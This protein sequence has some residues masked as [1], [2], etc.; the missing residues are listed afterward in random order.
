LRGKHKPIYTPHVDTGDFV[1]VI[2]AEKVKLTGRK[3]EAKMYHHHTGWVGG[4]VS[5]SAEEV[6][7]SKPEHL[8]KHA[9][10]GMLPRGPLGRQMFSKLKVYAG[11]EHPHAAQKPVVLQPESRGE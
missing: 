5:K 1:I 6:R 4:I 7:E 10:R 2:N 9:V 8:I 3:D 11:G